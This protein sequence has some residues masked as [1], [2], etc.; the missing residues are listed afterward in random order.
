MRTRLI[1]FAWAVLLGACSDTPDDVG[2]SVAAWTASPTDTLD[3]SLSAGSVLRQFI[4]PHA[5]GTRLRLRLS[6]RLG[7]SDIALSAV[8]IGVQRDG[9]NLVSGSM[10]SLRFGGETSVTIRAGATVLSDPL[11]FPLR[12]FER[13]GISF[14]LAA[15]G[16][17]LPR[18]YQALERPY[19]ALVGADAASGSG[20]G[21][22]PLALE[23]FA[24]WFLIDALE[25]QGGATRNTVVALG[26]SI[27][28]G[29]TPTLPCAGIATDPQAFGADLRY[30]DALAR[31]L[32]AVGRTD[33]S[34]VNAGI[35]GNRVNADGSQ[36]QHGPSLQARLV[37]DVLSLPNVRTAILLEGINDLGLGLP[38][39]A[40][41]LIDGLDAVVRSL[42][43]AGV[44]VVLGTLPPALGFCIGPLAEL[45]PV[46]GVLSGSAAV[47]A[48][49]EQVNDWI[50][51]QSPADAVVDFD[52]CLRDP[53]RPSYLDP[54]Y[55]SGD[56]LHP[57]ADGY[58]RMA[59]CIDLDQL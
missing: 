20:S 9:A 47:A 3:L 54:R 14:T 41:A 2:Q 10:R 13:V 6:N 19:L 32:L 59:D 1:L 55:D 7:T 26:D 12:A 15:P 21:F 25:V 35:S 29:Y 11:D 56:H 51:T 52:A 24:S 22:L 50:R 53:Q 44:R 39:D 45:A 49:R 30:P 48:A 5:D 34:V 36:A 31:R 37:D 42:Q 58:Q 27:T 57:N 46:P 18:H 16:T 28:D 8:T 33:L 40:Q 4:A 23:Q 43:H 38:P 17:S